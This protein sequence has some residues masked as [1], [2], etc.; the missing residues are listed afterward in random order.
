MIDD[1]LS[2]ELAHLELL[3]EWVPPHLVGE[4]QRIYDRLVPVSDDSFEQSHRVFQIVSQ[5]AS[6]L[7]ASVADQRLAQCEILLNA[8]SYGTLARMPVADIR[9]CAWWAPNWAW[10]RTRRT[11]DLEQPPRDADEMAR[12]AEQIAP[13]LLRSGAVSLASFYS[14]IA[15][16][17]GWL[18]R[19]RSGLAGSV[20]DR[21]DSVA[22][23]R[24]AR[25]RRRRFR[26]GPGADGHYLPRWPEPADVTGAN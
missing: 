19:L 1:R 2:L 9:D 15:R 8:A 17:A 13:Q 10:Y 23:L 22:T 20:G 6:G 4:R 14:Q 12:L 26:A 18:T 24:L 5:D 25:E 3:D 11:L 21:E 7:A 16:R